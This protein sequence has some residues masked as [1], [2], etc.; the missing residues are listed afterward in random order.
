MRAV[1][2]GPSDPVVS[3]D[4]FAYRVNGCLVTGRIGWKRI[5]ITSIIGV[6]VSMTLEC[7]MEIV[8]S[9]DC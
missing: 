2:T 4:L 9:S 5:K 7:R 8:Y 3:E 6:L 1:D